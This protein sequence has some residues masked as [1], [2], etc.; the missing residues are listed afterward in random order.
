VIEIQHIDGYTSLYAHNEKNLV[1]LGDI[2]TKG[3][4]IALL[5]STGR[6]NGP[7]VHLEVHQNGKHI[8]PSR[9]IR[10]P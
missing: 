4:V 9:F 8:N 10:A 7:H 3:Q 5:G 2:I 6:S 1:G